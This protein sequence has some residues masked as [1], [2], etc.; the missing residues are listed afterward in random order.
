MIESYEA[1]SKRQLKE[2]TELQRV[3]DEAEKYN[4]E[5][6]AAEADIKHCEESLQKAQ[7]VA[8]IG[9][10]EFDLRTYGLV[11]SKEH[12]RIFE[13]PEDTPPEI[14]HEA[15]RS[16]IY[17]EDLIPLDKI[18]TEAT[19]KGVWWD[20]YEHRVMCQD[21]SIKYVVSYGEVIKDANGKPIILH[22]TTQD[23]S[24]RK[25]S[26]AALA[27]S[28]RKLKRSLKIGNLGTY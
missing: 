28:E 2:N 11:W 24:E 5:L 6:L 13:L 19:E 22:G 21:G 12:F 27:F 3:K 10:W 9:S 4:R 20:S 14:L 7:R 26:E 16:K 18:V 15:Y 8:K 23:I 25:K 1:I 17:P